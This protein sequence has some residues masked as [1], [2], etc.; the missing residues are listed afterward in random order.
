MQKKPQITIKNI[1]SFL[2]GNFQLV[3]KELNLQPKHIQ[4][5]IAYRR[6]ICAND[7]A[8]TNKCVVCGC[9]FKGKTSVVE[10][11]NKGERF[12]D[13]MNNLEWHQFKKENNIE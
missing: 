7:C 6:L 9:D 5:Q 13:L 2:E 12:P 3:L 11:C 8:V 10:S 4:E 1:K